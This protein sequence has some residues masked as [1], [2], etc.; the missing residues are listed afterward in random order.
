MID[1]RALLATQPDAIRPI[2]AGK[3]AD[4]RA[5]LRWRAFVLATHRDHHTLVYL[6]RLIWL[7]RVFPIDLDTAARLDAGMAE[8]C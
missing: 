5:I 8:R 7:N 6:N 4:R 1:W 2:L 3:A